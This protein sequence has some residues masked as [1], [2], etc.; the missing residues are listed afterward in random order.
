MSNEQEKPLKIVVRLPD[1][2]HRRLMALPFLHALKEKEPEAQIHL[3]SSEE[4]I[5]ILSLLPFDAFVHPVKKEEYEKAADTFRLGR[6]NSQMRD[7]DLYFGLEPRFHD[8][9]FGFV[10]QAKKRIGFAADMK[11]MMFTDFIPWE[12]ANHP[13]ANY[14]KLL[15]LHTGEDHREMKNVFSKELEPLVPESEQ[16]FLV[17]NLSLDELGSVDVRWKEM[18]E[19]LKG[20][21][22][23]TFLEGVEDQKALELVGQTLHEWGIDYAKPVGL[24]HPYQ[25]A[26]LMY[27]AQLVVSFDSYL[28]HMANY[29][30]V[31]AIGIYQTDQ[32]ATKAPL[33]FG[34]RF[35]EVTCDDFS[36]VDL[37]KLFDSYLPS[38]FKQDT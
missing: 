33:Y 12:E 27:Q 32:A 18:L 11:K 17:L 15:G 38:F 36:Q 2:D 26:R 14:L 29:L 5:E 35:T 13:A 16:P 8:S 31:P 30:A 37:G 28:L 1:D 10:I 9:F 25:V 23:F 19:L 6:L 21:N 4:N 34:G 22:I 3:F 7:V 24:A 20:N